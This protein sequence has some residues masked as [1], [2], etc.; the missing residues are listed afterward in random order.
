MHSPPKDFSSCE[1]KQGCYR[2]GSR[3]GSD[4]SLCDLT[5][6]TL[7]G[8]AVTTRKLLALVHD[9]LRI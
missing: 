6:M 2:N 3:N 4:T 8:A 1:P 9:F 5:S 7:C